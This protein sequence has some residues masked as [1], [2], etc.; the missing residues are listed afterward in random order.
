M[1]M[2]FQ[3]QQQL[4]QSRIAFVVILLVVSLSSYHANFHVVTASRPQW[5]RI[6]HRI[7][8]LRTTAHGKRHSSTSA[9]TPLIFFTVPKGISSTCDEM[10]QIIC[11]LEKECHL[12][13]E[14]LDVLRHP[15]HEAVLNKVIHSIHT[16]SPT[17]GGGTTASTVNHNHPS[18]IQPQPPLLYH[19]ESRQVY[20]V[21]PNPPASTTTTKSSTSTST[22]H[23]KPYI[24]P[25][26]IRAW[27]KGRYLSP[28][29]ATSGT[30]PNI[31]KSS[32]PILVQ[33]EN[34]HHEEEVDSSPI[35][36]LLDEM[37]LS[38][39]QLKG[40]RLMEERTRAKAT[41]K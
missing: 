33:D 19:R 34:R 29:L 38:P 16:A 30:V 26:R 25:E 41:S 6:R 17:I 27:A 37:A 32:A 22:T 12:H 15:E 5:S 40:K 24:D 21:L 39:E 36:S 18:L 28:F 1:L 2:P 35:E 11:Q 3:L 31:P 4:K 23:L 9:Y 7:P 8:F 10:E 20:Q 14:R 13:V